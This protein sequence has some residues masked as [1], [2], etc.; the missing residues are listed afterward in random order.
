VPNGID[1]ARVDAPVLPAELAAAR[2]TLG[3][4]DGRR[5]VVVVARRKDQDVLLA[6]LNAVGPP[7]LVAC[8]GVEPDAQL[9]ARAAAI[10]SRHR[11]VFVPF[12]P[13]PLAYY[14]LADVA[15]LPSRIEG[16]SQTM[17]EAMALGVPVIASDAG[18]NP[19]LVTDSVTGLLVAP[20]DPQAWAVGL[21]RMLAPTD[22]AQRL[23]RAGRTLVRRE[24]T[25]ER[26]A[27]RTE[28]VYGEA[29][30]RRAQLLRRDA[31]M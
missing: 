27:L 30:A 28:T 29:L 5:V 12:V 3:E 7:T 13:R 11:A 4:T 20:L 6:A 10:P 2:A 26:T 18:G 23:A 22:F 15:A 31:P 16:L 21:S 25:L 14:R 24:F 8:V 19:D 9:L 1:L 17:L